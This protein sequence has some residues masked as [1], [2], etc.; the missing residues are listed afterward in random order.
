MC[1]SCPDVT[2]ST[3]HSWKRTCAK[4]SKTPAQDTHRSLAVPL[5]TPR[6]SWDVLW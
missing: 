6:T 2:Q 3:G 4:F 5:K 1:S